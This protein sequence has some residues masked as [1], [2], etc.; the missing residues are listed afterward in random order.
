MK[1]ELVRFRVYDQQGKYHQSYVV[2]ADAKACAKHIRGT[3]LSIDEDKAK[4]KKS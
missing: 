1:K 2:E 4:N 3:Y